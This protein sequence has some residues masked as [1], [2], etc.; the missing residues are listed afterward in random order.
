[1]AAYI[2][3]DHWHHEPPV[4]RSAKHQRPRPAAGLHVHQRRLNIPRLRDPLYHLARPK[5]ET[6]TDFAK[7]QAHFSPG[8]N[9]PCP[10]TICAT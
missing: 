2:E 10:A 4:D 5:T 7:I 9:P 6:T 3:K 8:F 1:L